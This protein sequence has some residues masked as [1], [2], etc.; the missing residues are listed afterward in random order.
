M[1]L[2]RKVPQ[3]EVWVNGILRGAAGVDVTTGAG[4]IIATGT[5]T[6]DPRVAAPIP[7]DVVE[8]KGGWRGEIQTMMTGLVDKTSVKIGPKALTFTV[9]GTL[10]RAQKPLGIPPLDPGADVDPDTGQPIPIQTWSSVT[11]GQIVKDVLDLCGI[12]YDAADI[13]ENGTLLGVLEPVALARNQP[14]LDFIK[15]IDDAY[16]CRTFNAPD[17]RVV[18]EVWSGLPPLSPGLVFTQGQNIQNVERTT[19]IT[20]MYNRIN[21]TG[22][23]ADAGTASATVQEDSKINPNTG[24]PYIPT[25]PQYQADA[26]SSPFL[27]TGAACAAYGTTFIGIHNRTQEQVSGDLPVGNATLRGGMGCYIVAPDVGLGAASAFRIENVHHILDG[28]R[29]FNTALTFQGGYANEGADT[30]L[31]PTANFTMSILQEHISGGATIYVILC[32]GSSSTDPDSAYSIPPT[33]NEVGESVPGVDFNGIVMYQ[34]TSTLGVTP[35]IAEHGAR[36]VFVTDADPTGQSITLTVYDPQ[37]ATG[38][39]TKTIAL[40]G[41]TQPLVRDL[42]LARNDNLLFTDDGEVTWHTFGI[43][44]VFVCEQAGDTFQLAIDTSGVLHKCLTDLTSSVPASAPTNC[45]AASIRFLSGQTAVTGERCWLGTANGQIWH[46]TDSGATWAL[47]GTIPG[48]AAVVSVGESPF[49]E[50]DIYVTAGNAAYHSYDGATFTELYHHPNTD[51]VAT[52]MASGFDLHFVAFH[53]PQPAVDPENEDSRIQETSGVVDGD[54][55]KASTPISLPAG[56]YTA[57]ITYTAAGGETLPSPQTVVAIASGQV[58]QFPVLTPLPAGATGVNYYLSQV[59]GSSTLRRCANGTGNDLITIDTA[60]A[61]GIAPPT[62]NTTLAGL[63]APTSA[64]AATA[65]TPA[66][67]VAD[68][69]AQPNAIALGPYAPDLYAVGEA[70]DGSGEAWYARGDAPFTFTRGVYPTDQLGIPND[71]KPD[72]QFPGIILGAADTGVF[73]TTSGFQA[74]CFQIL[75]IVS[76]GLGLK[77]GQGK[78]HAPVVPPGALIMSASKFAGTGS[79]TQYI[80]ARRSATGT[81]T[82]LSDHPDQV[83]T[84]RLRPLVY[85]GGTTYVTWTSQLNER[86][87]DVASGENNCWISTDGCATW[88]VAPITG[89]RYVAA[90]PGVVAYATSTAYPAWRSDDNGATWNT[91]TNYPSNW[92]AIGIALSPSN[93][94][95]IALKQDWGL[96][97]STDGGTTW[98]ASNPPGDI[99][100]VDYR[101][102]GIGRAPSD[103]ATLWFSMQVGTVRLADGLA[104]GSSGTTAPDSPSTVSG[105]YTGGQFANYGSNTVYWFDQAQSIYRSDDDGANYTMIYRTDNVPPTPQNALGVQAIYVDAASGDLFIAVTNSSFG[106]IGLLVQRAGDTTLTDATGDMLTALNGIYGGYLLGMVQG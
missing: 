87:D 102:H 44:A 84:V 33:V 94:D 77:L 86:G 36:A 27:E 13:Q 57:E 71:I 1:A 17:G 66:G 4:V 68:W 61:A 101:S 30:N 88:N 59:A 60:P 73:K 45:T 49:A 67:V 83:S 62:T 58:V 39:T 10:A 93:P 8:I 14:P 92:A 74:D 79:G 91:I 82:K 63:A 16:W 34:W 99:G 28:Q 9:L 38:A 20:G 47:A 52:K 37:L 15:G 72:S 32:D 54:W 46:S 6:L 7:T 76:P 21:V 104:S 25:P 35:T 56:N 69:P 22:L 53:G 50:N 90:V 96:T 19:D 42:W 23:Q 80:I 48:G 5:V 106:T 40:T 78:L 41:A 51:L 70:P 85:L 81:W 100:T 89:V 31:Y 97:V 11:D 18:R 75:D 43:P 29:G 2:I 26:F 65:V 55:Q 12:P 95:F 103:T 98:E 64:P 24:L 3:G 105:F